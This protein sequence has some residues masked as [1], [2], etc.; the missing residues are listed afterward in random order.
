MELN[1]IDTGA[2][3]GVINDSV[4][5]HEESESNN[6]GDNWNPG[7]LLAEKGLFD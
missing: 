5:V 7:A 2:V 1:K 3:T 6:E 4:G